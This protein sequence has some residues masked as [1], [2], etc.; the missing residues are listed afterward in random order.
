MHIRLAKSS[1]LSQIAMLDKLANKTAWDM[2]QYESCLANADQTIYV[3][4]IDLV[5]CG[6]LVVSLAFD[7]L[8]ILQLVIANE[9][10]NKKLATFLL[11]EVM[12]MQDTMTVI[13]KV[14]LEVRVD[15]YSALALYKKLGFTQIAI[16][17]NY[18]RVNGNKIDAAVMML[19]YAKS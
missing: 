10:Q 19:N 11:S 3:L 15:N 16:R 4:E 13:S 6:V 14:F 1:E 9:Y 7:E 8:E 2:V 12:A 5:I 17:K 18:Y